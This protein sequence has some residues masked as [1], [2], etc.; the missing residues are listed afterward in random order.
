MHPTR[1]HTIAGAILAVGMAATIGA[2]ADLTCD[3]MVNVAYDDPALAVH[4][5][6]D[7][8]A[9]QGIQ[10]IGDRLYLLADHTTGLIVELDTTLQ[11]TG[12]R[13]TLTVQGKDLVGHPTGLAWRDGAPTFLGTGG[14]IY[15]IDWDLLLAD[16]TLDRAIRKAISTNQRGA[17]PEYMLV[18]GT[19]YVASSEYDPP[20]RHN[21]LL[22]MDPAALAAADSIE[23]AGV[24]VHRFPIPQYV[25]DLHWDDTAQAAVLVQNI[26]W[27]RGW[28]LTTL[29]LATAISTGTGTGSAITSTRCILRPSEL[30]GYT[31][32]AN[33]AEV[34]VTADTLENIYVTK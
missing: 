9:G 14:T 12:W 28:R 27:V 6:T 15:H 30:E 23:D 19:W 31:Q 21:E 5:L 22:L 33:T 29:D 2:C 10:R 26:A 25:Q 13:A 32:L 17:R 7:V 20:D 24:I 11:P 34:F 8:G 16:R 4:P 1:R 3:G 18:N